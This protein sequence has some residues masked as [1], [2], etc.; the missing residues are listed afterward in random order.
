MQ[1][2]KKEMSITA[3]SNKYWLEKNKFKVERYLRRHHERQDWMTV[4]ALLYDSHP[5]EGRKLIENYNLPETYKK[6]MLVEWLIFQ[7]QISC[8]VFADQRMGKDALIC[9]LFEDCIQYIKDNPKY[10]IKP[11]RIVTLGNIRC[12]PFVDPKDMYFSFKNI[13]S[14]TKEREV[15]I[16][17]SEI[18]TQL[19][20]REG[21]SAE[22]KL[23]SQLE[24]TMAQNHQKLFGCCKLASKVD[25][26][27]IRGMNCKLFKYI[28]PEKLNIEGVERVNVLSPLGYWLL[29][30]DHRDKSRSL[31][32][33]DNQLFTVNYNLPSF[34][35]DEYSEQFR[36]IPM[37][38]I[39]EYVDTVFSE[40]MG[41][42]SIQ[43][44]V[45]QKFR[46][47]LSK[48]EICKYLGVEF[49]KRLISF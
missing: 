12:P 26:N 9:K 32:S 40:D 42:N 22:N 1:Q 45:A 11:P 21:M 16:Y 20:A 48:E 4:L 43:I 6:K 2:L 29:P 14:G 8:G 49:K 7:K 30:P 39:W 44:A 31:V 37:D 47:S 46:V 10:H 27:F 3:Q 15:W 33:F 24:G 5:D 36:D 41:I 38:K 28:S 13:P 18:E 35:S 17:S 25:L 19:P 23:F 34:W